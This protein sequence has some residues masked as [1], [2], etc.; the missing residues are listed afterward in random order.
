[1][2]RDKDPIALANEVRQFFAE[3]G[4]STSISI[5]KETQIGQ[6][7][8]YRNIFG[9]PKRVTASLKKLCKY[10]N[11]N[12]QEETPDPSSSD[13]LMEALASIWDGSETHALYIA[14]LL[15]ALRRARLR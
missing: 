2:K 5:A 4:C 12:Y 1:M 8:V 9:Q 7:Q 11:I 15:I 10:A 13:I 6:S 14:Q 3:K